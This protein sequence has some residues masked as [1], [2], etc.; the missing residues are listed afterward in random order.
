MSGISDLSAVSILPR[1]ARDDVFRMEALMARID[2][3]PRGERRKVILQIEA[4]LG[5]KRGFDEKSLYRKYQR[6]VAAG[7]TRAGLI[8]R[9]ALR[10]LECRSAIYHCFKHYCENNQRG[11]RAAWRTLIEDLCAGKSL[12]HGVG[13][14]RAVYRVE[15][16]P[17]A[18]L[19]AQ[20]PYSLERPP[21]GWTYGR[22]MQVA[23]LS[24]FEKTAARI[25]MNAAR[26]YILPVLTTRVGLHLGEYL[27]F[28]DKW[29]DVECN[30]V[31]Q[32][33]SVRPLEFVCRDVLSAATWARGIRPRVFNESTGKRE[34]LKEREMRFM[35]AYILTEVGV[36]KGGA[37]FVLEHG[38]AALSDEDIARVNRLHPGL[39]TPVRSGIISDQ[40]HAGMWAGSEG[41]NYRIKALLES[42][43][44]LDHSALAML[45]GQV[46]RNRESCPEQ[47]KHL[48]AYNVELIKAA[49]QLS[50]ERRRMLLWPIL[51][52][53]QLVQI[54]NELYERLEDR[55]WHSLEGWEECGFVIAEY[56]LGDGSNWFPVS[57][58]DQMSLDQ[59]RAIEAYL[60]ANPTC[61]RVRRLSPREVRARLR[62]ELITLPLYCIPDLLRHE[63]GFETRVEHNGTIQFEDQYLGPQ[64]HVFHATV[65]TPAGFHQALVP[66]LR[67]WV[68]ITPY[69]PNHLFVS[70]AESG[71]ILGVAPRYDRAPRYDIE[72]IHRLQGLQAHHRSELS[73]PIKG[74]HQ[75]EAEQRAALLA[76][77]AAVIA[78]EP[79]TDEEKARARGIRDVDIDAELRLERARIEREA[80]EGEPT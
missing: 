40:V 17:D 46:G 18:E 34:N 51:P 67:Y 52:F 73:A 44:G 60:D 59:R 26:E 10:R 76:N 70:D 45:P 80:Q 16:G 22:L 62:H 20:C 38:T 23:G 7:R 48:S 50:E 58:L 69:Q 4:D 68:H 57:T 14:W 42:L 33:R 61:K 55:K 64:I 32:G 47:F 78:G 31:G 36:Y 66:G 63:D 54:A 13:D 2:R 72:A 71:A 37:K 21:E 24:M 49:A 65:V 39:I 27:Q 43:H 1:A 41:G 30:V 56:R 15:H 75:Q 25:G 53:S 9:A 28:D 74:R 77:N 6:W 5:F 11:S 3:A 35:V 79:V 8:N 12:P 29:W 19:P